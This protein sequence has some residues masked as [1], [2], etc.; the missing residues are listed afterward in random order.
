[1]ASYAESCK[2]RRCLILGDGDFS[3]TCDFLL[4]SHLEFSQVITSSLE[5][6]EYILTK[7]K[8]GASVEQIGKY[9]NATILFGLDATKLHE[10][11]EVLGSKFD[12]IIFNFPHVGGK[13]NIGANR[14]LLKCFLLS[15]SLC[16]A[17]QGY[18][19][20]ALC[21]GQGGQPFISV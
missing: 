7:K 1:M 16:L 5:S 2:G 18:I 6:R 15:S 3:F 12:Q 20:V 19:D 21:Q 14:R 13:S 10:S 11:G 4:H 17:E 9:P 8:G